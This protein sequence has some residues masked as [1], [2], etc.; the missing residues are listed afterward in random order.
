MNLIVN[1]ICS[2]F[3]T[4][5]EIG[6]ALGMET[7]VKTDDFAK[8]NVGCALDEGPPSLTDGFTIS[9]AERTI[10]RNIEYNLPRNICQETK[11]KR[12]K[13]KCFLGYIVH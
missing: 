7:F 11:K 4:D 13:L 1:L 10:W 2:F 6:G 12:I 3:C 8:L 5:E 9:Y